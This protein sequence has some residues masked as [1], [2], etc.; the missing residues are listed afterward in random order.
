MARSEPVFQYQEIA[1][2][3]KEQ[4][5]RGDFRPNGRLPSERVLGQRFQVQRNT[6]RQA[7][8]VLE[9]DGQI[10][11]E[12][13][14]G[15]FIRIP[16]TQQVRNTFLVNVHGGTSPNL[17]RLM[18]GFN[19]AAEH[20]GFTVRR[21]NTHPL[22]G[23]ALD[24]IPTPESLP[25]DTAGIVLWPQSPTD[26][27]ALTKLNET[28]PLVLVDRRVLG[29]SA[30]C[31]RFDD[32]TGGR[33]VCEHLIQQGHR[34]IAFIADELFAETVQQRWRGYVMALEQHGVPI[35]PRQSLFFHGIDQPYF[36]LSM[37][38]LLSNPKE[39]PTAIMCSNDLV[40]FVLLRFLRDEGLR[41]PD[42][43]AVTGYGNSMPDYTEAMALTSVEQSFS[44]MG[45]AAADILF[46][47]LT[48]TREERLR[49]PRDFLIPTELVVRHSSS[50]SHADKFLESAR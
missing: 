46:E 10:S 33:L 8:A 17:S 29:V 24:R 6:I 44:R 45:Q 7:L 32:L 49:E 2:E 21:I 13:K 19:H 41:V 27:E 22:M 25:E 40:A 47:R 5:L 39:R 20:G 4:I 15:S 31:V 23:A 50:Y 43:V 42:D 30:D 16:P 11:T 1:R 26:T 14:K 18:D 48:Q 28:L 34:R 35:D 37:R 3:L 12:N 38:H 36:V 9:R